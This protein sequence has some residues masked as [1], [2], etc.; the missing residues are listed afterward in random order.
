MKLS[1]ENR[2]TLFIYLHQ[3][4]E[5]SANTTTNHIFHGRLN[6]L[7]NYPPNGGLTEN[8]IK[9]IEEL[10]G[11]ENLKLALRKLF[12]S[13]TSDVFFDFL[14]VIDG[15]SNPGPG[16]GEWS[17]VILMDKPEDFDD[18]IELLHDHFYESYWDWKRKRISNKPPLDLE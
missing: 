1:E 10:K 5:E 3:L 7:I 15:T 6:Q 4:I 8:E 2:S 18:D 13:N 11:N 16:A 17:E 12:A 9:A 14:N